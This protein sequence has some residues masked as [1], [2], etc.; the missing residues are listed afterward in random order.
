MKAHLKLFL[1]IIFMTILNGPVL[2]S[3]KERKEIRE[4]VQQTLSK[5][6]ELQPSAKSAVQ[7]A[8]GYAVF[9][10]V[11][12]KILLAG[13]GMGKGIAMD[14]AAGKETFM[15]MVEVQAGLGMGIKKFNVIFVFGN[16]EVLNDFVESGWQFG[17]QATAAAK[18][19]EEG[20]ALAGAVSVSPGVWI[21]QLTDK[22]LA[23]ELTLKGTRY[24]KDEDLN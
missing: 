19:K 17:G 7:N 23:L 16:S 9:N 13:T 18:Y 15:K 11:G 8:T 1:F 5:L 10:N 21:Y 3:E 22:G 6:Y 4:E 24:Y 20:D 14:N 12:V 2:A